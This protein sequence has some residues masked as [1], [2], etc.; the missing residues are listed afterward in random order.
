VDVAVPRHACPRG[1]PAV[2]PGHAAAHRRLR[3]AAPSAAGGVPAAERR[4]GGAG[5]GHTGARWEGR[6]RDRHRRAGEHRRRARGPDRRHRRRRGR[7]R[8]RHPVVLGPDR[9]GPDPRP[10]CHGV[11]PRPA[12][13][14]GVLH[15]YPH[16]SSG[17][18]AQQRR[19]RGAAGVQRHPV[20]G[21]GEHRHPRA[22]PRGHA[23]LVVAGHRARADAAAGLRGAGAADRAAP[24]AAGAR[25]GR[26]QR[27][28]GD[29][30][31]GAVLRARRHAGQAVRPAVRRVARVRCAR[32]AGPRHRGAHRDGPVGV[33]HGAD[34]GLGPG[35]GPGLRPGRLPGAPR[36][37]GGGRRRRAGPADHPALRPVDG[38]GRGSGR[39]DERSSAS[40]GC[41]RCS[42]CRR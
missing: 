42:T 26:P 19:H 6:R 36:E 28:D 31:D 4:R 24:G 41:S 1:A 25:G 39:G 3:P 29:P 38:A 27:G 9:R 40:A 21:R 23:H 2:L 11:L 22:R 5:C 32:R 17:Q 30:D 33:R 37:D 16:G 12:H 14:G 8:D 10:A 18:P 34:H 13:A 7:A 20:R 35:A 15:A